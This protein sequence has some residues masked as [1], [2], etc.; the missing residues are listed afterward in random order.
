MT[1]SRTTWAFELAAIVFAF[2]TL[3]DAQNQSCDQSDQTVLCITKA[4]MDD[5]HLEP[6]AGGRLWRAFQYQYQISEQPAFT[7]VSTGKS[8]T[9]IIPNTEGY[10]NQ[11][12]LSFQFSELFPRI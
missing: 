7:A 8:G 3:S 5:F 1:R 4:S 9:A 12:D 10:M 6:S 2:C 11:H